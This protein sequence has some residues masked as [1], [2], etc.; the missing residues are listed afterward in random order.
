VSDSK[1]AGDIDK[2]Y[3]LI[4]DTMKLFENSAYGKT[5]TNKEKFVSTSYGNEDNFPK[6][7]IVRIL[8]F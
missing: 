6:R 8:K 2:A 3:G 7:L 4:S 5:A 1:S